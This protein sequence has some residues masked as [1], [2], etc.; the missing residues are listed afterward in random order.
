MNPLD[1]LLNTIHHANEHFIQPAW[2]QAEPLLQDLGSQ[3][4]QSLD[5]KQVAQLV[6]DQTWQNVQNFAQAPDY[7]QP[8]PYEPAPSFEQPPHE[9]QPPP[10]FEPSP[11]LLDWHHP[12]GLRM[13]FEPEY[14]LNEANKALADAAYHTDQAATHGENATWYA[15]NRDK[16]VFGENKADFQANW[17]AEEADKAN[18]KLKEAADEMA[19][20]STTS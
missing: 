5:P 11:A 16:V 3:A 8:Q 17:A 4:L 10:L 14:H 7:N 1:P 2:E 15:E 20:A 12:V 19:K 18:A 6:P 13:G 9:F